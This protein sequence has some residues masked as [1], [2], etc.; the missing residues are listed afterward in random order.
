MI[1]I[2]TAEQIKKMAES[3]R[4]LAEI[5]RDMMAAAKPGVTT[6]EIDDLARV[7]CAK[8][9]VTPGFYNYPVMG[10]KYPA[11]S[12]LSVNDAVVH[13]IPADRP[14]K[15]GDV[16]GIDM[17]VMYQGWHSDSAVT[18][19]VTQNVQRATSDSDATRYT[20]HDK[21]I[22][23]TKQAMYKG[24]EQAHP[25]NHV[26]DIGYAVQTYVE[27]HGFG[28]VRDLVGHGIGRELHEEPRIP[29]FGKAGEGPELKA[30][31]V[32]CIEPMVTIGDWK[33]VLD[34]DGWTYR[35]KDGSL[36]AHFE[37]TVAIT[38]DGPVILTK[39]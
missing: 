12:C 33:L 32:V 1:T 28:V 3:G 14:L 15:E 22:E 11:V 7:L 25:G 39:L 29:N 5:I 4:I 37:H 23:V 18:L 6:Q 2:K 34:N 17:G 30:G 16:L 8:H 9:R 36:A 31:M 19:R 27:S 10:K 21:L 20:L 13:A 35:T 24:I 26:G 38:K